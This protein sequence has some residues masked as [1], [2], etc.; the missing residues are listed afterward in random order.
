[1]IGRSKLGEGECCLDVWFDPE[2]GVLVYVETRDREGSVLEAR[3][4]TLSQLVQELGIA[5][6]DG[7][8][9]VL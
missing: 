7:G 4:F 1:M 8:D 9:I 6:D 3:V 5:W 2:K